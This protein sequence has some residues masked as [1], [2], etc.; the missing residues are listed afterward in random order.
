[1]LDLYKGVI[2]GVHRVPS[3]RAVDVRPVYLK[4]EMMKGQG[5]A[6]G[7]STCRYEEPHADAIRLGADRGTRPCVVPRLRDDSAGSERSQRR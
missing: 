1:M 5:L 4:N 3:F 2:A 6:G 7:G